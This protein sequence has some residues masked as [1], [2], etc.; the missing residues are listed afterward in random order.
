M[1]T[2]T[3]NPVRGS[4]AGAGAVATLAAHPS[5]DPIKAMLHLARSRGDVIGASAGAEAR[6]ENDRVQRFL[7]AAVSAGSTLPGNWSQPLA[8]EAQ[9]LGDAFVLYNRPTTILGKLAG[10]TKLPP[11]VKVPRQTSG[12]TG[13]WVRQGA[14]KPLTRWEHD[15]LE[16]DAHKCATIS[17]FTDEIL[18][19]ANNGMLKN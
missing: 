11:N 17:I 8:Q 3:Y 9:T 4:K 19:D 2:K 12:G 13:Y 18:R 6:G 1:T 10:L 15:L 16:L 14:S 7:K 5:Y